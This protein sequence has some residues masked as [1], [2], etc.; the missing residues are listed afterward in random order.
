MSSLGSNRLA[1]AQRDSCSRIHPTPTGDGTTMG[2]EADDSGRG[3]DGRRVKPVVGCVSSLLLRE[4]PREII[5]LFPKTPIF[6]LSKKS[7]ISFTW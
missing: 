1:A 5:I 3:R 6:H 7:S 4:L 2:G